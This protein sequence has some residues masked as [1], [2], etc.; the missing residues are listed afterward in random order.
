MLDVDGILLLL[1]LILGHI[2]GD[3]FLQP[4]SWV[5]GKLEIKSRCKYLCLH[6]LVHGVLT[7][8]ILLFFLDSVMGILYISFIVAISHGVVDLVKLSAGKGFKWFIVDQIAHIL[9]LILIW[10]WLYQ[11]IVPEIIT[12]LKKLNYTHIV[13][14]VIAYLMMFQPS[15]VLVGEILSKWSPELRNEPTSSLT[16]AGRYLGYIE[17]IIILTFVLAAQYSAIG[18]VL[19]AKSIFRM[20]DLREAKDRK[21][22]E[23]VMLGTLFSVSMALS[24]GLFMTE[25]L[26][27]KALLS[28]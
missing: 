5:K 27:L 23:Y 2:F 22:T 26:G 3:F 12:I 11:A 6:S 20:G 25:V 9:V 18:F 15:A 1:L 28:K 10:L 4:D 16:G 13:A 17:R 21:F 24:T 14:Y 19:A 8:T 7:G